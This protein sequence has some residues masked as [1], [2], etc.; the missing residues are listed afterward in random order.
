[1]THD[2]YF[3]VVGIAGDDADGHV[4]SYSAPHPATGAP[5]GPVTDHTGRLAGAHVWR[6]V[7]KSPGVPDELAG[8]F[9]DVKDYAPMSWMLRV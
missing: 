7:M 4:Y 3:G 9:P 5:L 6:T 1:M 2:G 8:S